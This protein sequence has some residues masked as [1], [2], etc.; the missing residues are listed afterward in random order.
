MRKMMFNDLC[1]LTQLVLDGKKTQTRRAVP[2][3][4][5]RKWDR[6][7]QSITGLDKRK[8]LL[9]S[10]PLKVGD[11]VAVAQSYAA[12]L[13]D[14][15]NPKN[16]TCMGHW[17]SASAK[18]AMYAEM[19]GHPGFVNK[20]F[21]SADLMPHRIRIARVRVE[22]IGDI[23]EADCLREGIWGWNNVGFKGITYWYPNL[24]NSIF[25]TARA[26]YESLLRRIGCGRLWDE[27]G[28]VY[29]YD[30]ELV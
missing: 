4:L 14:L 20:M 2:D 7:P 3:R 9:D 22:N 30:F 17:D 5:M 6:S 13:D 1:G 19:F 28:L 24:C 23:S 10:S 12:I 29:V 8:F 11:V 27:N 26:A 15:E 21:I 16:F 25:R 18:R